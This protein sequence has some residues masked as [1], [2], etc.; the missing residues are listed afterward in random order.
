MTMRAAQFRQ[1]CALV[2][3]SCVRGSQTIRASKNSKCAHRDSRG[4]KGELRQ[5]SKLH[6]M[7]CSCQ[8]AQLDHWGVEA[9]QEV[10]V[11]CCLQT[12]ME[13]L[14]GPCQHCIPPEV[15]LMYTDTGQSSK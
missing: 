5:A 8:C 13:M 6:D 1:R 15:L 3:V 7:S 2:A 11:V 10:G 14:D 12:L 4:E 9:K